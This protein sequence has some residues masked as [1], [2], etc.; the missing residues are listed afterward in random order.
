[1]SHYATPSA[2]Y[3]YA[4][5]IPSVLLGDR[6]PVGPR[7]PPGPP[8]PRGNKGEKGDKGKHRCV[9]SEVLGFSRG[10]LTLG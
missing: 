10:H 6:G 7:G 9:T 5:V 2:L 1:M 3:S 8:G 4:G